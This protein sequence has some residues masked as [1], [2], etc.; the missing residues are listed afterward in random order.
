MQ[1]NPSLTYLIISLFHSYE[2]ENPIIKINRSY[3]N[4]TKNKNELV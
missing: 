3:S 2:Y 1:Y 4:L